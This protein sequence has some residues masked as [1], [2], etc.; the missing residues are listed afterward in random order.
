MQAFLL[1]LAFKII[2]HYLDIGREE[3]MWSIEYKRKQKEREQTAS[4]AVE[5]LQKPHDPSLT[6]DD[7]NKA[8]E[9]AFDRFRT[10][11]PKRR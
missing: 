8:E 11:L 1:N 7:L 5:E 10:T 2:K 4:Q 9:D 3:L 6:G